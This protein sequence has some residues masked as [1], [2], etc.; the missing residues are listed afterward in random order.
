MKLRPPFVI[1][2]L[3]EVD[4]ENSAFEA[5]KEE[6]EIA[7]RSLSTTSVLNVAIRKQML[8]KWK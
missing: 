6:S 8:R 3:R 1:Y 2:I 5:T 4:T 7:S